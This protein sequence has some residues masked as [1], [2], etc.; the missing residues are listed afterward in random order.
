MRG[1]AA[2]PVVPAPK[3]A[4]P[5]IPAQPALSL[6]LLAFAAVY[7]IWGSTYLGIRIAI[8]SMPP[9]LMA[10]CRFVLAGLVLFAVMRGRGVARP[11]AAHWRS[12]LV[13]GALLLLAGNGGVTWAEKTVPSGIAALVVAATPLWM[14]LIDWLRP[15]GLR[16]TL[17][18]VCGLAVGFAG[19]ALIVG[20]RNN[21]GHRIVD[22]T[23]AA[24]LIFATICW[25]FG[26]VFSRHAAKPESA[27][28]GVAMQMIGGGGLQ[29]V[30][31][32][33]LG[34]GGQFHF[35]MITA[36]SAWAFAYLTVFGSLIGYTAYVWLLQVSTP[37]RVSTYAYVNPLIAVLLGKLILDEPVPHT[38]VLAGALILTAVI[39]ITRQ[40]QRR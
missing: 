34:E 17:S 25:A 40:S 11:N 20:S 26:S 1:L 14:M 33:A 39:L 6:V 7:L 37:A 38:V 12:A 36:R 32:F 15:G 29:I 24:A 13:I 3:K 10:G 27:L 5:D 22:P 19:V 31:G 23:G 4:G 28:L 21:L 8:E 16:P 30:T 2:T 18:V 35:E 9:F